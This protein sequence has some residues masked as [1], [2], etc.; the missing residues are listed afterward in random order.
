MKKYRTED[1]YLVRMAEKINYQY[2]VYEK[3]YIAVRE[4]DKIHNETN[5]FVIEKGVTI[6][7]QWHS[8]TYAIAKGEGTIYKLTSLTGNFLKRRLS[9][10]DV[11]QVQK[12]FNEDY[13]K[14]QERI[15]EEQKREQE[16]IKEEQ[17]LPF[18][19]KIVD[20]DPKYL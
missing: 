7:D 2:H 15:K 10:Q 11:F 12:D 16:R 6:R 5:F 1:L 18:T 20:I 4:F 13:K 17:S 19:V 3:Y 14:E 8:E 9:E